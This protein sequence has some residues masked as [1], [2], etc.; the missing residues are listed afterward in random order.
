MAPV[1]T[2]DG[3]KAVLSAE[4]ENDGRWLAA[5]WVIDLSSGETTLLTAE[6]DEGLFHGAVSYTH[7]GRAAFITGSF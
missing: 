4:V 7:L 6:E 5:P 2:A 1:F 3:Q